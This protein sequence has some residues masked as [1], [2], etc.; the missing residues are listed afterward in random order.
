MGFKRMSRV[1]E[2]LKKRKA[3]E[4]EMLMLQT[5]GMHLYSMEVYRSRPRNSYNRGEVGCAK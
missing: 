1:V 4:L 5:A 3:A 2:A